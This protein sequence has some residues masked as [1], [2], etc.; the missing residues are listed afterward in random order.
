MS[1]WIAEELDAIGE[2]DELQIAVL[3]A[4]GSLRPYTTIWVVRVG[5][6][7]YVRSY[8]AAIAPGSSR[9]C[10]APRAASGPQESTVTSPSPNPIAPT[11]T[12]STRH[13]GINTPGTP[14]LTSTR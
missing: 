10:D 6:D 4:D 7:L 2:A 12:P 3:R 9:H 5:D 11:M 14:A 8:R 13:T 1:N